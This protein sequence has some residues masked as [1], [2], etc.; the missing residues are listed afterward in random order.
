MTELRRPGT[1]HPSA[2]LAVEPGRRRVP[3]RGPASK[4][5][6]CRPVRAT[7]APFDEC[8]D[9]LGGGA[10]V[11]RA[12]RTGRHAISGQSR[13]PRT[14]RSRALGLGIIGGHIRTGTERALIGQFAFGAG[15]TPWLW[16]RARPGRVAVIRAD[17]AAAAY[18][19]QPGLAPALSSDP[20]PVRQPAALSVCLWL[21]GA[22]AGGG[23]PHGRP[24]C[25]GAVLC[26]ADR[27]LS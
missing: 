8:R 13:M 7:A 10:G 3:G 22:T 11:L 20:S 25:G 18:E 14:R 16:R 17:G 12:R 26:A 6:C 19:D 27:C 2:R 5:P 4:A 15:V 24:G 1:G 21:T 9:V 23:T